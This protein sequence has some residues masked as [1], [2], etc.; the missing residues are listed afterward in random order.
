MMAS[1]VGLMDWSV[2]DR[3]VLDILV[4][5]EPGCQGLDFMVVSKGLS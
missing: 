4:A 3:L 5:A 2:I 1:H